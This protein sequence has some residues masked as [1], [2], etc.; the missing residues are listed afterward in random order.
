MASGNMSLH[1]PRYLPRRKSSSGVLESAETLVDNLDSLSDI[2]DEI[3]AKY[4]KVY[5]PR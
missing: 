4:E 1:P 5:D 3:T 2:L